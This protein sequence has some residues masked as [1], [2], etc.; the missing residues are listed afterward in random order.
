MRSI[1]ANGEELD[2]LTVT[3]LRK[4]VTS[5]TT[6]DCVSI[7]K[8]LLDYHLMAK[9]KAEMDEFKCGL[10]VLGAL[11]LIKSNPSLWET[12]FIH[13]DKDNLSPGS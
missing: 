2:L 6:G 1:F 7:S 9:V 3:G 5:L 11:D 8:A 12:Y 10:E 4:P 13:N